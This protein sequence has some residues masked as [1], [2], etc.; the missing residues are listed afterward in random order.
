MND[1]ELLGNRRRET[2]IARNPRLSSC[3][4]SAYFGRN[5]GISGEVFREVFARRCSRMR[6]QHAG[7][8]DEQIEKEKLEDSEKAVD[9]AR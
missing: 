2:T 7:K 4:A 3:P 8:N 1:V 6:E 5:V 9:R